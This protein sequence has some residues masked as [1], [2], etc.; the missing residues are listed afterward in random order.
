MAAIPHGGWS[1]QSGGMPGGITTRTLIDCHGKR[2]Q[3]VGWEPYKQDVA[4]S[5]R[6]QPI[7][8][9]PLLTRTSTAGR[10]DRRPLPALSDQRDVPESVR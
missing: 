6:A 9:S 8:R 10:S 4:R 1:G 2:R 5:I 7:H 3:T